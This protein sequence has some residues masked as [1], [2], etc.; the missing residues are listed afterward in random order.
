MVDF[1]CET[2]SDTSPLVPTSNAEGVRLISPEVE[3]PCGQAGRHGA[4]N[5]S[6]AIGI[7]CRRRKQV[8]K[9]D[10]R[11]QY[12]RSCNHGGRV[13]ACGTLIRVGLVPALAS[14]QR[15]CERACRHHC[16]ERRNTKS[17]G[18]VRNAHGLAGW[19]GR[20]ARLAANLELRIQFRNAPQPRDLR[21][22]SSDGE[23]RVI[24]LGRMCAKKR[25]IRAVGLRD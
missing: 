10:V 24:V 4:V 8:A 16:A 1:P 11:I 2:W 3:S 5:I 12:R 25:R 13:A 22:R 7:R 17:R 6:V 15:A 9:P 18:R 20:V 14:R 21:S 19:L 23:Y